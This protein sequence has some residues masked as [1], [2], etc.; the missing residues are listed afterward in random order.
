M[1]TDQANGGNISLLIRP[2]T[3]QLAAS[4]AFR[5]AMEGLALAGEGG[6]PGLTPQQALD[7]DAAAARAAGKVGMA[8][9]PGTVV[10]WIYGEPGHAGLGRSCHEEVRSGFTRW[11]RDSSMG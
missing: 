11:L 9:N 7:A 10:A 1:F 6:E 5:A 2:V 3:P 4:T 8:A